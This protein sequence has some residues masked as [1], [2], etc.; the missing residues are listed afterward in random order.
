VV[1]YNIALEVEQEER[2]ED[3]DLEADEFFPCH[4]EL[5]QDRQAPFPATGVPGD[6]SLAEGRERRV[7][8]Q[9]ALFQAHGV[10]AD[11]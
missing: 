4:D 2:A 3:N 10:D 11:D 8:L 7:Q 5:V 9:Q 6:S 1:V